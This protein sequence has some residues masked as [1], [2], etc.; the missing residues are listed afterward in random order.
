M[1][2]I[3]SA[4]VDLCFKDLFCNFLVDGDQVLDDNSTSKHDL[5]ICV[6]EQVE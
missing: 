5:I 6:G 2:A 4:K 1:L 3:Q